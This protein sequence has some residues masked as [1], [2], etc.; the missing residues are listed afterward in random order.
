M[1]VKD[2]KRNPH[3]NA[4]CTLTGGTRSKMIGP[5]A[6]A[7]AARCGVLT[8]ELAFDVVADVIVVAVIGSTT[9]TAAAFFGLRARGDFFADLGVAELVDGRFC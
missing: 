5:V 3:H 4:P 8:T 7:G 2:A 6:A 1:D 9:A